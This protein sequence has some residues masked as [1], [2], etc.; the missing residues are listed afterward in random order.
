MS[1][2]ICRFAPALLILIF[3]GFAF[4]DDFKSLTI[5]AGGLETILVHNGQFMI[6]RNFTQE[7]GSD[8]GIVTAT[9]PPTST[10]PADATTVLTAAILD[11][12][13]TP[14]DI[15]NTVVIAGP[16]DVVFH[17]GAS[18]GNCFVSFKKDSN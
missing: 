11:T 5:S 4:G 3:S 1:K 7:G 2:I 15:I 6:I 18:G 8:R 10:A 14:P 13:T 9:R 16:A 17:C 12:T